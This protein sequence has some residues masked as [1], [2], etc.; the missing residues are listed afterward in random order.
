MQ[1]NYKD[2]AVRA[3]PFINHGVQTRSV[4]SRHL[5][6]SGNSVNVSQHS[7]FWTHLFRLQPIVGRSSPEKLDGAQADNNVIPPIR[8][9]EY[10]HD[11]CSTHSSAT[12]LSGPWT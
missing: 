8:W 4:N 9:S 7:I 12:P 1:Y 2:F 10:A 5:L 11:A 3:N 6:C